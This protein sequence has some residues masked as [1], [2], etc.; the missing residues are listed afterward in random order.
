MENK[1][2]KAYNQKN[3]VSSKE[4]KIIS[5]KDDE[6]RSEKMK[7]NLRMKEGGKMRKTK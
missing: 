3:E 7:A 2:N 1:G 6:D 4:G 5:N